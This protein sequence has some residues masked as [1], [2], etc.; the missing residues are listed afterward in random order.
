MKI[1]MKTSL[2][3][4]VCF[5]LVLSGCQSFNNKS[6]DSDLTN[7]NSAEFF[8]KSGWQACAIG[9]GI[10]GAT[11]YLIKQDI[12]TCLIAAA[13]TCGVAMGGNYYLDAKRSEYA[14]EEARLDAYI[15][16]VKANTAQV[17]SVTDSAQNVLNKN[18]ATL[19]K[20]D[21]EIAENKVNSVEA[22]Q[23]LHNIDANISYL[24]EKLE[25]M[26]TVEQDWRSISAKEKQAGVNVTRLDEQITQL[27]KQI[28][29]LENQ[30]N[31]V[32]Q[33]RSAL[34]NV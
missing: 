27:N 17:K 31:L 11:C 10:G 30:I 32:T 13:A 28:S 8:S 22:R 34:R 24:N 3:L 18:L 23:E 12:T 29:V 19:K 14:D 5:S 15:E 21:N 20:L 33:Q 7:D 1:K 25:R 26:K 9:A 4:M 16:D 6:V 2:V